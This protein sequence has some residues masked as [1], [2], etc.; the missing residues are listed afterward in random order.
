MNSLL[1]KFKIKFYYCFE[2]DS[3]S[4]DE[5]VFSAVDFVS[6]SATF[7][8]DGACSFS[9]LFT[10]LASSSDPFLE[11]GCAFSSFLV[12]EPLSVES[13]VYSST[14]DD[15]ASLVSTLF[16]VSSYLETSFSSFFSSLNGLLSMLPPLTAGKC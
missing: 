14:G 10:L 15:L 2:T 9:E 12:S 6:F 11:S 7:K 8:S 1:R 16:A 5:V 13:A 3:C 4:L